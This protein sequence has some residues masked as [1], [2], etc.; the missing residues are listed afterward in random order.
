M[1]QNKSEQITFSYIQI[2]AGPQSVG[3]MLISLPETPLEL[4]ATMLTACDKRHAY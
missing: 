1:I 2:S 3:L 4:N